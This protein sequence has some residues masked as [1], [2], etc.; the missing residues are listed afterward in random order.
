MDRAPTAEAVRL[1][2]HLN[3]TMALVASRAGAKALTL[4]LTI[5]P[6]LPLVHGAAGELNQVWLNL[7]DNA[8]DA[9]PDG[10]QVS[11]TATRERNA[12]MIR[13][14]DN[15]GGIAEEHLPRIF[16]PF[17]TTKPV[18]QGE[19]LGLDIV[20]TVVGQHRGAVEVESRPG[21]TEFRV[22]LPACDG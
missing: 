11:V 19:G 14:A 22:C 21:H 9:A 3:D 20:R 15:G 6:N 2:T 7:V 10:G 8:I 18:G 12:V 17:F 13:V 1:D 5:E 4:A 16:D